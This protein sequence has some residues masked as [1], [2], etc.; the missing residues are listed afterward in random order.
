MNIEDSCFGFVGLGLIGGSIAKTIRRIYPN[1]TIMAY[2]RT[3]AVAEAAKAEGVADIICREVDEHFA[4][5]DYIFLCMPVSYNAQYLSTLAPL[6][7]KSCILTDVGSSKTDIH[8]HVRR[9]GLEGQFIGGHPMAGSDKTGYEY[10]TNHMIEGAYYIITPTKQSD[11]HAVEDYRR[12]VQSLGARPLILDYQEH[13]YMTAAISHVPHLAASALAHLARDLDTEGTMGDIAAGGFRDTTRIAA[14]SPTM[15][16][17]I[18][19]TNSENVC[20]VLDSYIETLQ[21]V[22]DMV[23]THASADIYRF[24]EEARE[25]R[26]SLPENKSA[27]PTQLF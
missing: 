2:N 14:S 3:F 9:L 24:L 7:K 17:Q 4:G 21:S 5:C 22:R 27:L 8:E 18:C 6:V 20:K 1:A 13:D 23:H 25:Y 12:L 26:S 10:A 16:Q 15:W 11:K 19:L